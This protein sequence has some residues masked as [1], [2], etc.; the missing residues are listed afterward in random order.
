[1]QHQ[2]GKTWAE[3]NFG[4]NMLSGMM[5]LPVEKPGATKSITQSFLSSKMQFLVERS[6]VKNELRTSCSV[7]WCDI[8][9]ET[10]EPKKIL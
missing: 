1:M 5:H 2:F 3:E 10:L 6:A 9:L 8:N 7:A 4:K